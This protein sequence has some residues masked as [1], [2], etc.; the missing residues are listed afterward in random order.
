MAVCGILWRLYRRPWVPQQSAIAKMS[1]VCSHLCSSSYIVLTYQPFCLFLPD[2]HVWLCDT[3]FY[4]RKIIRNN[5]INRW[6]CLTWFKEEQV[7]KKI[8]TTLRGQIGTWIKSKWTLRLPHLPLLCSGFLSSIRR[9]RLWCLQLSPTIYLDQQLLPPPASV[10]KVNFASHFKTVNPD[11]PCLF[12]DP[13]IPASGNLALFFQSFKWAVAC[14]WLVRYDI[15]M[16]S[17][18]KVIGWI[19]HQEIAS[20]GFP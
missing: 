5:I 16:K 11:C 6:A 12:N 10:E 19:G 2:S 18:K 14:V 17:C 13:M 7:L 20:T 4:G 9:S 15:A 8:W 1:W 3:S